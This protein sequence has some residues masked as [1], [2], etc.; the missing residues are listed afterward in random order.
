MTL[1][2]PESQLDLASKPD[3]RAVILVRLETYSDFV[4]GTVDRV[5][6]WSNVPLKY[7][8]DGGAE[9][10]WDRVVT[11]VTQVSRGFD[12]I[13][14]GANLAIRE[15]VSISVD[16][17]EKGGDYLWELL[18]GTNLIGAKVEVASMLLPDWKGARWWDQSGS[19]IQHVVRF[20]GEVA[21]VPTFRDEEASFTLVCNATEPTLQW[22]RALDVDTVDPRD[23][24]KRY[25]VPVGTVKR[26]PLINREVGATTTLV[27]PMAIDYTGQFS[28]SSLEGFP[29]SGNFFVTIGEEALQVSY[30]NA[31]TLQVVSRGAFG[32][33]ASGHGVGTTIVEIVTDTRFVVSG[34]ECKSVANLYLKADGGG[35]Y[36]IPKSRYNFNP[37]NGQLDPGATLGVVSLDRNQLIRVLNESGLEVAQQPTA[38]VVTLGFEAR[39][40]P[41][42][43]WDGTQTSIYSQNCESTAFTVEGDAQGLRYN[44]SV[45]DQ[46]AG[47]MYISAAA[48]PDQ[49]RVVNRFRVAFDVRV[50]SGNQ[51]TTYARY[52]LDDF[53]NISNFNQELYTLPPR[54]DDVRVQV[55]TPWYTPSAGTTL[56]DVANDVGGSSS[57]RIFTYLDQSAGGDGG[58]ATEAFVYVRN[59]VLQL[60]LVP[61]EQTTSPL[62]LAEVSGAA[63]SGNGLT[64]LAD[65]VGVVEPGTPV[66]SGIDFT[67]TAGWT[68]INGTGATDGT[69]IEV[70]SPTFIQ[71]LARHPW[72]VDL[73]AA[74][75]RVYFDLLANFANKNQFEASEGYAL[76]IVLNSASG[77]TE[78]GFGPAD[79]IGNVDT[80]LCVDLDQPHLSRVIAGSGADRSAIN[81]IDFRATWQTATGAPTEYFRVSNL[82]YSV[83]STPIRISNVPDWIA[84]HMADSPDLIDAASF[85]QAS[86]NLGDVSLNGDL[87]LG[88]ETMADLMATI[89]WNTRTNIGGA[90]SPS[91]PIYKAWN[92]ASD[93]T[94]PAAIRELADFRA[95]EV[96]TKEIDEQ[97]TQ[98]EALFDLDHARFGSGNDSYRSLARSNETDNDLDPEVPTAD[99][100]A[101]Q[102]RVGVRASNASIFDLLTVEPQMARVWGYYVHE[103]LRGHAQRFSCVVSYREGYDLEAGDVVSLT[104]RWASAPIKARVIGVVFNPQR[105]EITLRLEEVE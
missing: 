19:G 82:R 76:S 63:K 87:R 49:T 14:D 66:D 52:G 72:V 7:A 3:V 88:G 98:F 39:T 94:F 86:V 58:A 54:G 32:T 5:Y 31:L 84:T 10:F 30:V 37:A 59:C 105:P 12:H 1:A 65:C 23:L 62:D 90:E 27:D 13:P 11:D 55:A 92:A 16:T 83:A 85:T 33:T 68:F 56:A 73:S 4:A 24:G 79:V 89:G 8:W 50:E 99:I 57:P 38:E 70:N 46:E 104:P 35:Y 97:P 20:R 40:V 80:T 60:E 100:V 26:L 102:A 64:F 17:T 34:Y 18:E 22:P 75:T 95:L 69:R 45:G 103:A 6:Y 21:V 9:V 28:V 67:S 29:D 61:Q 93:F 91:G 15:G 71:A 96:T 81:S 43:S 77:Q 41:F 53:L 74:G 101:A 44:Y 42:T 36:R 48:I 25:P 47:T 78:Y 2:V 51:N